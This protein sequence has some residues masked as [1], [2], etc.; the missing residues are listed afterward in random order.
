MLCCT[1]FWVEMARRG[2]KFRESH[3]SGL[4]GAGKAGTVNLSIGPSWV[5]QRI[6][7]FPSPC[8]VWHMLTVVLREELLRLERS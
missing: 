7:W 5:P 8:L 3:R 2:P 6:W 4:E 1:C